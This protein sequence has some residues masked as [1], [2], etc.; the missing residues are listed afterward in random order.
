MGEMERNWIR[1][2]VTKDKKILQKTGR[3]RGNYNLHQTSIGISPPS[4]SI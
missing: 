2:L 1:N 4:C 3:R